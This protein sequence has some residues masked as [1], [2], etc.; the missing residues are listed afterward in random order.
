MS[1]CHT[2]ACKRSVP[3][4]IIIC[5]A[6]LSSWT[7][8]NNNASLS[9]IYPKVNAALRSAGHLKNDHKLPKLG[10]ILN[11]QER[12]ML[13]ANLKKEERFRDRRNFHLVIRYSGNWRKPEH[14]AMHELRNKFGLK[15]L[16]V[17]M[18]Y[19]NTIQIWSKCYLQIS[20]KKMDD[21][22]NGFN[23]AWEIL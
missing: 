1:S 4:G 8:N 17:R 14:K 22:F 13:E 15:W 19:K 3:R 16:C 5:L 10:A 23:L 6:G 9:N 21:I 20:I 12:E 2:R 11:A 7:K 18:V